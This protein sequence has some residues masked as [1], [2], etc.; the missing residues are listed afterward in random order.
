MVHE[1]VEGSR[2]PEGSEPCD[3]RQGTGVRVQERLS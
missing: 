2:F 1:W 3:H